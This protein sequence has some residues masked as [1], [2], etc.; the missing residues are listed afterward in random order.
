M[1]DRSSPAG[2][3]SPSLPADSSHPGDQAHVCAGLSPRTVV[4]CT[5]Y[6]CLHLAAHLSARWF[7]IGSGISVWYPPAG[8][9][10]GVLLV[11]GT[12]FAPLVLIANLAGSLVL[13]EFT[14]RWP[15]FVFP[16]IVTLNYTLVADFIQRRLKGQILP[17]ST[18]SAL[19][20]AAVVTVAPI[21]T[22]L[23]CCL[24][25]VLRGSI[26]WAEFWPSAMQWWIGDLSGL[27][28][29][30]PVVLVFITPWYQGKPHPAQRW[31][32]NWRTIVGLVIEGAALVASLAFVFAQKT[33]L[34]H[35]TLYVC[36]L[37]LI[38]ICLRH[39]LPGATFAVLTLVMGAL[40]GMH[41]T[42]QGDLYLFSFLLFGLAVSVLGLGMGSAVT[43]RE[44][45]R[46]ELANRQAR[47]DRVIAGAQLGLWDWNL[48]TD[49]V[50][51]NDRCAALLNG[52][53]SSL[54]TS[55]AEWEQRI[56]PSDRLR[57]QAALNAHM[58]EMAPLY[59]CEYRIHGQDGH[60]R[61]IQSR[62]SVVERTPS[63]EPLLFS[64]THMDVTDRKLAEEAAKR[65]RTV[66]DATTD[67]VLT[68]DAHGL[69][70]YANIAFL[71]LIG[72][73]LED[74]SGRP[75][76]TVVSG[77]VAERLQTQ[78]IPSTFA[79]G[80]WQ[81]E[82]VLSDRTQTEIPTSV[83]AIVH[84]VTEDEGSL[85]SLVMRDIMEQKHAE[86]TKLE[87]ERRVLQVQK[88]ESLSVLAGGMAHDFNNLL[89]AILGN[90]ELI[91]FELSPENSATALL[92]QIEIAANRAAELCR[93]MLAYSGRFQLT[94]TDIDLNAL[95][96]ESRKLITMAICKKITLVTELTPSLVRLRGCAAQLQQVV[97]NLVLN[98][99][100]AIGDQT[101]TIVIRT[102]ERTFQRA[103]I[104]SGRDNSTIAAGHYLVLEVADSGCGI[105]PELKD[106][107][108]DPFFTTKRSGH[109]LGLSAVDGIVRAH[110]GGIQLESER[111][112]GSVF[113]IILPVAPAQVRVPVNEPT[114]P[115]TWSG[116]GLA[117]VVDDE[118][119]VRTVVA[120]TIERFGFRTVVAA[121][122][123][124]GVARF[125]EHH[126]ELSFV[127]TD[128][129]M[130]RMNGDEAIAEMRRINPT[131]PF[132]LM[133]GYPE[134]M[135]T[136]HFA[137]S[138]PSA[139]LVKP[140]RAQVLRQ[141]LSRILRE[142]TANGISAK[143]V[144]QA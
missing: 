99:S 80:H 27:L 24:L 117:L 62:G 70:I 28:T 127:L 100:D 37:P 135:A 42:A 122:G 112:Q 83:V 6:L 25:S 39:G 23:A 18:R 136:D 4:V 64:G 78:I 142:R 1:T 137:F 86:A 131:I 140:L 134:K 21:G 30:L 72:R 9:A 139:L 47:F 121:D 3:P 61:W 107:V 88:A 69:V 13:A 93:N 87:Q 55:W 81:G 66:L 97:I 114:D 106:K 51:W 60:W 45:A 35:G 29:V 123:L 111:N 71:R 43:R 119:M 49:Q 82:I 96:E 129:T 10:V 15:A 5:A 79:N 73:N 20:F 54:P 128:L 63:G 98:A 22:T 118:V 92:R 74:V 104:A 19:T 143:S 132:L 65:L 58:S 52:P 130:P 44:D 38:W 53:A 36:F 31:S 133:S 138:N 50:V 115:E 101:G 76:S 109:G 103:Q 144:D 113:R 116:S 91:R 102:A 77:P 89:T 17:R 48:K 85:L 124:E 75:F 108:F 46:R 8:L 32:W 40:I 16:V 95:V 110:G 34:P 56:H 12:Q 67:F 105:A 26:T 126:H 7:E 59:Q 90:A 120:L 14:M 11:L 41:I 33:V 125:K 94:L 141:T 68:I 2:Q 84:R 57:H